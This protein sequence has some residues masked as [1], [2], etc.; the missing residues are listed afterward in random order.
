M[1]NESGWSHLH[2]LRPW[3]KRGGRWGLRDGGEPWRQYLD[4]PVWVKCRFL[5]QNFEIV[6]CRKQNEAVASV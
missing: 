1:G 6:G 5:E 3:L 2:R 4:L